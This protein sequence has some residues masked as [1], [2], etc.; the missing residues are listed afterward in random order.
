[1]KLSFRTLIK[2]KKVKNILKTL[3]KERE[4]GKPGLSISELSEKTGIERHKL[5]GIIEVL[6]ILGVL[7]IIEMG[8]VKMVTVNPS[9]LKTVSEVLMIKSGTRM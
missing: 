2:N 8:M 5:S 9:T 7:A 1:M 4:E 6:G 3:F